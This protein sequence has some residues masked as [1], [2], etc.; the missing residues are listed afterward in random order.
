MRNPRLRSL[1]KFQLTRDY[2][3]GVISKFC[4]EK[5]IGTLNSFRNYFALS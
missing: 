1:V 2:N 4:S 5:I 3:H